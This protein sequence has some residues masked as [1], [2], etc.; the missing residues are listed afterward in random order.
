MNAGDH[1]CAVAAIREVEALI[2]DFENIRLPLH[3]KLILLFV[4]PIFYMEYIP[5][6]AVALFT[7]Y[8]RSW[9]AIRRVNFAESEKGK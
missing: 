6:V 9:D 5:I 3:R 1:Q 7:P 4:H 8:G 2:A